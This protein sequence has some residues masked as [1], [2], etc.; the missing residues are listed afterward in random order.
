LNGIN[1]NGTARTFIFE[2][3]NQYD[4]VLDNSGAVMLPL[5]A[6]VVRSDRKSKIMYNTYEIDF[7]FISDTCI[8]SFDRACSNLF[9]NYTCDLV[10]FNT[11]V[12]ETGFYWEFTLYDLKKGEVRLVKMNEKGD[13]DTSKSRTK[14]IDDVVA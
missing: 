10:T 14:K 5:K 6:I 1:K 13:I 12:N 9:E 7:K 3:I 8:K 2:F 4:T 11:N